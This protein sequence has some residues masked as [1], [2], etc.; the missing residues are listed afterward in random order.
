MTVMTVLG[1]DV[2]NKRIGVAVG[3]TLT[4][5]ANPVTIL[6]AQNLKPDW[7]RVRELISE[8]RPK[9]IVMGMPDHADDTENPVATAVI[10]MARRLE[11]DFRVPI[12]FIDERLSSVEAKNHLNKNG[13]QS[14]KAS[15]KPVDDIAAQ[16]I[17]QSWLDEQT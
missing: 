9:A 6:K 12:Y 16:I 17:L 1:F 8:W 15:H 11:Q 3:Q 2:G 5:T 13:Q 14:I 10:K 7:Q 4:K